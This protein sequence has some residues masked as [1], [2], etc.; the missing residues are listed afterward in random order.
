M[1]EYTNHLLKPFC[2][3]LLENSDENSPIDFIAKQ[4]ITHMQLIKH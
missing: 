4:R 2:I 1:T 3:S